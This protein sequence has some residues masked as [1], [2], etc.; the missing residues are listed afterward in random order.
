MTWIED[1]Y[2]F[3]CSDG[4]KRTMEEIGMLTEKGIKTSIIRKAVRTWRKQIPQ[5][6]LYF[7]RKLTGSKQW[8]E[9]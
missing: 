7:P 8:C 3:R 2:E 6:K 1:D 4:E 9:T 5:D